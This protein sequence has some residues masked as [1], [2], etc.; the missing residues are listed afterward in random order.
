MG[1][2]ETWDCG[3]EGQGLSWQR[4][5]CE[6][7]T[8]LRVTEW[9]EEVSPRRG[10]RFELQRCGDTGGSR[11]CYPLLPWPSCP[12]RKE[13]AEG[14]WWGVHKGQGSCLELISVIEADPDS[15]HH[16]RV[17]ERVQNVL[18]HGVSHQVEM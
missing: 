18:G 16:P 17:E 8:T 13:R 12:G 15:R 14:C 5:V 4:R 1:I 6:Y 9:G 3:W 7:Q 2:Q 10:D 11:Q